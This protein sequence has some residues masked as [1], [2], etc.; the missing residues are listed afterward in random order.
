MK[1]L[2][3]PDIYWRIRELAVTARCTVGA[4]LKEAGVS[5]ATVHTWT[6]GDSKPHPNTIA[7]IQ[8]AHDRLTKAAQCSIQ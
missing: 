4:L 3:N 5:T 7:R 6:H 1:T 8:G 2:N